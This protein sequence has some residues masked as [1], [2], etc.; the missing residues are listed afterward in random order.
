MDKAYQY[1]LTKGFTLDCLVRLI[2]RHLDDLL[3]GDPV[4]VIR[5]RERKQRARV[6]AEL[7]KMAKR[8]KV[9]S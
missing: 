2:R 1:A 4:E 3:P 7:A 9:P 8:L 6:L 5:E